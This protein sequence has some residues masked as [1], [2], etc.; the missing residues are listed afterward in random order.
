MATLRRGRWAGQDIKVVQWANDW[1]SVDYPSG[2]TGIVTPTNII[3]TPDEVIA[4]S[5]K[6]TGMDRQYKLQPDGTFKR[7]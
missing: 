7:R 3:L 6:P 5:A 1:F 4:W 2:Q